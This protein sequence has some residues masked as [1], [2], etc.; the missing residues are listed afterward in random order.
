MHKIWDVA[1]VKSP[2]EMTKG[3]TSYCS[4]FM[5][6][7]NHKHYLDIASHTQQKNQSESA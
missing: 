5:K 7:V 3:A 2:A 1:R 4:S 6:L